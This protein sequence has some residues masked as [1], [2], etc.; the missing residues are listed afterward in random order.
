MLNRSETCLMGRRIMA[1]VLVAVLLLAAIPAGNVFAAPDAKKNLEPL[2]I[3]PGSSYRLSKYD[4]LDITIV[5]LSD[6]EGIPKGILI[7]PD[8]FVNLPY[9]GSMKLAGLT[10]PEA[11]VSLTEKLSEYFKIPSLSVMVTAYGPRKVYVMG[12]VNAQ[13][14]Y[15]LGSEYMNIFAAISSAGGIKKKGRPKH[16]AVVRVVDGKV[17]TQ[18]VNFDRFVEKQDASQNVI[19]QDGD[20]VYV[21]RSNKIDLTEDIMPLANIYLLYRAVK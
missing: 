7:G 9:V 8:G 16:I 1:A 11:T 14:I 18:T 2:P 4:Q 19:L 10:I 15:S 3:Q 21:P 13:G 12:E 5:G 20:M 17:Q 6:I